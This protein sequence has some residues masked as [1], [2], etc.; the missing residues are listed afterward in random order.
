MGG[1]RYPVI[2]DYIKA[3]NSTAEVYSMFGK[4]ANKM[5][6][7]LLSSTKRTSEY[8]AELIRLCQNIAILTES[9]YGR[10]AKASALGD[11]CAMLYGG[12]YGRVKATLDLRVTKYIHC[13]LEHG[14]EEIRKHTA[15]IYCQLARSLANDE[16]MALLS[17]DVGAK[18]GV[19]GSA[20]KRSL[21]DV[22]KDWSLVGYIYNQNAIRDPV[23]TKRYIAFAYDLPAVHFQQSRQ[24]LGE[25]AWA[26]KSPVFSSAILRQIKSATETL[27]NKY[28][29]FES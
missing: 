5:Y 7:E 16:A 20:S 21:P 28:F 13:F 12:S 3:C 19:S 2:C 9:S 22:N 17:P 11:I 1:P 8:Y 26:L 10:A 15:L 23:D 29:F 6:G 25:L 4:K 27:P 18:L 14:D 24:Y